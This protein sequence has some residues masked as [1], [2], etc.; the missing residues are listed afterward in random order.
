ME[1]NNLD[2][3]LNWNTEGQDWPN[4]DASRFVMAAGLRWHVQQFGPDPRMAPVVLLLHGT[5]SSTH[6]WRDV[7]PLLASRYA[8]LALD[9]PG[10]AFT[11]MPRPS[12]QSLPGIAQHVGALL[13]SL[14]LSP[15]IVVGHSAGAAIAARMLLDHA[16]APAALVSL[17]GAFFGYP[18]LAGQWF[19]PLTRLLASVPLAS[20]LFAWQATDPGLVEHWIRSTG[21]VL[22]PTG[23]KLYGRLVR[24]PR[25]VEAA[26]AMM[27]HWDLEP[28]E[29]QLPR[30]RAPVWMVAAEHDLTV[31]PAQA[32]QVSKM[33]PHARLTLWPMLGHLA[34]EEKPA[35][36]VRLIDEV[37]QSA[38]FTQATQATL[39]RQ[40][41]LRA[42]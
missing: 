27:A 7:A 38:R 39:T 21:S 24:N 3:R 25:H 34:H 28:L 30:I 41:R 19:S 33:L 36:C 23:L 15:A 31:P 13:A 35:L 14:R 22:D 1:T 12:E 6:S 8:V 42:N 10:H 37:W 5:G 40:R 18:G 32:Q 29:Q 20:Q 4:R 16:I 26:L 11:A 17:N 2:D 9:L